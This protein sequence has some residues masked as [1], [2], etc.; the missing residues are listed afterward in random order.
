MRVDIMQMEDLD[1]RIRKIA[2]DIEHQFGIELTLTS[3]I[4]PNDDGVHAFGRGLDFSCPD[5][6]LGRMLEAFVNQKYEYDPDRPEKKCALYHRVDG[7]E[8][9]LHL[10]SHPNTRPR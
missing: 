2:V 1:I 4:R 7:G 9:H 3:G 10:Q 8:W 6:H 5:R